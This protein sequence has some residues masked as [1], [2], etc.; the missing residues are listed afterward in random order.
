MSSLLTPR[1][2]AFL[3]LY[4]AL[5]QTVYSQHN[6]PSSLIDAR[7]FGMGQ[8]GVAAQ[9]PTNFIN[10]TA[11][12][13][14]IRNTSIHANYQNYYFING[15]NQINI[16]GSIPV[17]NGSF[18]IH[19]SHDGSR[20]F[21]E[22]IIGLAYARK[23]ATNSSIGFQINGLSRNQLESGNTFTLIPSL[24]AVIR[25]IP[26]LT[27]AS[28]INNPLPI[29]KNKKP[30][31]G[32]QFKIGLNY[33]IYKLLFLQT[34]VKNTSNQP[35]RLHIG[36]EYCPSEMF[37]I[38]TGYISNGIISFGVGIKF[39]ERLVLDFGHEIHPKLGHSSS[40]GLAY[41]LF[42]YKSTSD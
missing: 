41:N 3:L 9:N 21:N 32:T 39:K 29:E 28:Q 26:S 7:A 20:E 15:L 12:L 13:Y 30:I 27:L 40:L 25:I 24:G 37:Q 23:I 5:I 8:T 19:L 35:T 11:H 22:K 14:F 1:L 2:S 42:L 34:E 16:Q 36:I 4:F 17:L 38:R 31:A 33:Q 10:N 18:G 6:V